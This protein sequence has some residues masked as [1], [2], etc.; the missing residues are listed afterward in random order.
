MMM[1]AIKKKITNQKFLQ[2]KIL[3]KCYRDIHKQ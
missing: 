1:A 2:G 3:K